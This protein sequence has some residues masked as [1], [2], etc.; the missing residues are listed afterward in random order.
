MRRRRRRTRSG[1][2]SSRGRRRA[3]LHALRAERAAAPLR[4]RRARRAA[5]LGAL[6][7]LLGFARRAQLLDP[8]VLLGL[9]RA[10][11]V[12]QAQLLRGD[13][14]VATADARLDLPHQQAPREVQAPREPGRLQHRVERV[15]PEVEADALL[16]PLGRQQALR[17]ALGA[18]ALV[19]R[20]AC[21]RPGLL[22]EV[23][24]VPAEG[25]DH[26]LERPVAQQAPEAIHA[27]DHKDGLPSADESSGQLPGRHHLLILDDG[28]PVGAGD[29]SCGARS[30]LDLRRKVEGDGPPLVAVLGCAR[31]TRAPATA[32]LACH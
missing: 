24:G 10:Q 23:G 4:P 6:A 28:V 27:R 13:R 26:G 21:R 8:G 19:R 12:E 18:Q 11:P 25:V 31:Q 9:R 17:A 32:Y 15:L 20:K 30:A 2:G 1:R 7:R 5:L 22:W 29:G 16:R 14:P 3:P